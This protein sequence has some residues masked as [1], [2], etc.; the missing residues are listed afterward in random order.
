MSS[1]IASRL[2]RLCVLFEKGKS[3]SN[4]EIKIFLHE[5]YDLLCS[6]HGDI[7]VLS[8]Y[9]DKINET[10]ED[11]TQSISSIAQANAEISKRIEQQAQSTD[12]CAGITSIFE[13]HFEMMRESAKELVE[14]A[15]QTR[16]TSAYSEE[17]IKKLLGVNQKTQEQFLSIVNK[18]AILVEKA[19]SINGIISVIIRIARQTNLLSI[20][21]TIEAA[22][23]GIAGKGFAVVAREIKR[24]ADETQ[25]EGEAIATLIS[26]ITNEIN[27]IQ[28]LSENAKDDFIIQDKCILSSN[29]ALADIHQALSGLVD[30]QTQVC[31]NIEN[32]LSYKDE[33]VDSIS[34]IVILTEQSAAISQIVSSISME[35]ASRDGLGLN[36]IQTQK[37][38]ILDFQEQMSGIEV[39]DKEQKRLRIG[40]T[41][42]E[43]QQFYREVE[44][45]ARITGDKLNIEVVCESPKRFNIDEQASIFKSFIDA[46]LDGIVVV[47]SDTQRFSGLINEAVQKGIKVAC[48]DIDVPQSKRHI[49]ITS[50]SYDGGKLAG[51]AAIRLLKGSGNIIALLCAASVPTVQQRYKGFYDTISY[52]P[53][54]NIQKKEQFDTDLNK[55][56]RIIEEIISAHSDLDLL[57]MVNSDAGEIAIDIWRRRRLDK[58]II[59]LS[60]GEKITAGVKEGLVSS[61][62]IQRNSLWGEMA[63]ICINKLINNERVAPYENTGMFEINQI[64]LPIFEKY[65]S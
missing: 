2:Q 33:L 26:N 36:M 53:G 17:S 51:Q 7:Q 54:M 65:R 39:K 34:E 10:Y 9:A 23:A 11:R 29:D 47:P 12:Q 59:I 44:E 46:E 21:A 42:L 22:R 35:V 58:K 27:E 31:G 8:Q 5:V 40:F 3:W 63:I 43:Q 30:Q 4:N 25:N 55:T 48:V 49:Y 32:L 64:S 45:A 52:C 1:L 18:I 62:I 38:L 20:N 57:Y 16:E 37:N 61:Q 13:R 41:S 24:L 28:E 15:A 19:E 60:K 14:S 56:R 50:D 6:L